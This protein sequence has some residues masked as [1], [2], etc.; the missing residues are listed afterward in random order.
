MIRAPLS[1]ARLYTSNALPLSRF[2][3]TYDAFVS[4]VAAAAAVGPT[5]VPA[6]PTSMTIAPAMTARRSPRSRKGGAIGNLLNVDTVLPL[7]AWAAR[8]ARRGRCES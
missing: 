1:V 3:S 7:E 4:T 5:K 8:S 2:T 6:L